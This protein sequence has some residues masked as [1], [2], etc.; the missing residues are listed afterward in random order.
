GGFDL[1][2]PLTEFLL[3]GEE[4]FD[5]ALALGDNLEQ[6]RFHGAGRLEPA[7]EVVVLLADVL[8]ADVLALEL[9]QAAQLEE[10][11]VEPPGRAAED[12]GAAVFAVGQLVAVDGADESRL[13]LHELADRHEGGVERLDLILDLA[14][15]DDL[16]LRLGVG[17]GVR[18]RLL[19]L[20]ALA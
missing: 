11:R 17:L 3:R 1:G 16:A 9:A 2:A 4:V 18:G 12:A 20:T 14:G 19:G 15:A 13:L 8:A 6:P 10:E 5:L 7:L